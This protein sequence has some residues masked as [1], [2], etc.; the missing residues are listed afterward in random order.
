MKDRFAVIWSLDMCFDCD[1]IKGASGVVS[2]NLRSER[3][4]MPTT[5]IER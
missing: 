5:I 2:V 3:E 4:L 1:G